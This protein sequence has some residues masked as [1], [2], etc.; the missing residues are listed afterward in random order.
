[1]GSTYHVAPFISFIINDKVTA[2]VM[3]VRR[4]LLGRNK[5]NKFQVPLKEA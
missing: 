4:Y 1:M 3:A 2:F 5:N